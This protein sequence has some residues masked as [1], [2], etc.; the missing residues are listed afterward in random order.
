MSL[1]ERSWMFQRVSAQGSAFLKGGTRDLSQVVPFKWQLTEEQGWIRL[2]L[3]LSLR[4]GIPE[5]RDSGRCWSGTG[6]RFPA[7]S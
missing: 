1:Q 2:F 6:G 7:S 4:C 5:P 3:N